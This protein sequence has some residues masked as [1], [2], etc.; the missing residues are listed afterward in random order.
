MR[1]IQLIGQG[2][3]LLIVGL[4]SI[5]SAYAERQKKKKDESKDTQHSHHTRH[6]SD[7]DDIS[8][9]GDNEHSADYAGQ[10]DSSSSSDSDSIM[11]ETD[12]IFELLRT[13]DTSL[14]TFNGGIVQVT[15]EEIGLYGYHS[16]DSDF[17]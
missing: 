12:L 2:G 6:D 11:S 17:S 14:H 16:D 4:A 5:A 7:E 15:T 8:L 3:L 10:D 13:G 9:S 1:V